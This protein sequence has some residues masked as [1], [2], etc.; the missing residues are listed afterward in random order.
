MGA[1]H[2]TQVSGCPEADLK[3]WHRWATQRLLSLVGTPTRWA[4]LPSAARRR[5]E[6][7]GEG[8]ARP[9]QCR[10][11]LESGGGSQSPRFLRRGSAP[12]ERLSDPQPR[13]GLAPPTRRVPVENTPTSAALQKWRLLSTCAGWWGHAAGPWDLRPGRGHHL[14]GERA[15]TTREGPGASHCAGVG[16]AAA[17]RAFRRPHPAHSRT[18]AAALW[19]PRRPRLAAPG[20]QRQRRG[21]GGLDPD[22]RSVPGGGGAQARLCLTPAP[23]VWQRPTQASARAQASAPWAGPRPRPPQASVLAPPTSL[24]PRPRRGP[25]L[26][27]CLHGSE[28]ASPELP[29]LLEATRRAPACSGGGG[30]AATAPATARP[31]R[32]P[33]AGPPRG[34]APCSRPAAA[35]SSASGFGSVLAGAGSAVGHGGRTDH[36]QTDQ[37]VRAG[38]AVVGVQRVQRGNEGAAAGTKEAPPN[39]PRG[40]PCTGQPCGPQPVC[41]QRVRVTA[42]RPPW[43]RLWGLRVGLAGSSPHPGAPPPSLGRGPRPG[44]P[45]WGTP[46]GPL[47]RLF[48]FWVLNSWFSSLK[49]REV[50]VVCVFSV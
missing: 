36:R 32:T 5:R 34:P 19:G 48:S 29:R 44:W 42:P 23:A 46:E 15:K 27:A 28:P 47:F 24:W 17:A 35:S 3:A 40:P 16:G 8:P 13:G 50:P 1:N 22:P 6:W 49:T 9:H 26:T 33:R 20:S 21:A 31:P 30:A 37:E 43:Q 38:A 39:P 41:W 11:L 2:P 4:E 45:P 10:G 7:A 25:V 14:R 12:F 18:W